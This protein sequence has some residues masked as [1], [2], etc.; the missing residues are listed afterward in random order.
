VTYITGFVRVPQAEELVQRPLNALDALLLA[1]GGIFGT[2]RQGVEIGPIGP[3]IEI[4]QAE[5]GEKEWYAR[6]W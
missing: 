5:V 4:Q 6:D 2:E 3:Q 1:L